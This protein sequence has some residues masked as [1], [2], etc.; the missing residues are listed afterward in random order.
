VL[1]GA[2]V[3]FGAAEIFLEE[4]FL[5]KFSKSADL[6]P[7]KPKKPSPQAQGAKRRVPGLV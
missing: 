5:K 1:L 4:F 6:R 3:F 7:Q 2:R